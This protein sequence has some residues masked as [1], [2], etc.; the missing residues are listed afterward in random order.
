MRKALLAAAALALV[1]ACN[2]VMGASTPIE[3]SGTNADRNYQ[4]AG[5]ERISLAAPYQVNLTV[6]GAPSVSAQGDSAL[7][8]KTEILVED[9]RLVIRLQRGHNWSGAKGTINVT[10]PALNAADIAGSGDIRVS[11]F[12]AQSFAGSIA[13]SGN[14]SLE[15]LQADEARFNIAG[16]G[17]VSA[18]GTARNANIDIAG[19]GNARLS[20]LQ[21][22]SARISIAG[23]GNA[24]LNATGEASISIVGSGNANISGGARCQVSR[25]GSGNANCG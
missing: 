7:L 14:L 18:N 19:S 12:Q 21:S 1:G 11:P 3:A 8:E 4:V 10:A 9:G 13:G 22:Q 2:N 5:F 16:S 20:A 25:V 15:R 17:D 6:G 23:S 24:D